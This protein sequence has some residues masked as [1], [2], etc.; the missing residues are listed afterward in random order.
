[1]ARRQLHAL[2]RHEI[3][4]GLML[5]RQM[6]VHRGDDF[7]IALRPGDLEHLRMPVENLL[8]LRS[9]APG[10]DDFAVLG[11]RFADRI[12]RLIHGGIDEA[13]GVHHHE[14]RRAV[15][16][17]HLVPFG[18]QAREDALRI[19]ERLGASQAD[20][21]HFG[22]LAIGQFS[23]E[24]KPWRDCCSRGA[25]PPGPTAAGRARGTP[26]LSAHSTP[27]CPLAGSRRTGIAPGCELHCQIR[28]SKTVMQ[29]YEPR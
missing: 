25:R 22:S 18:A 20:E 5:G 13:A 6:L 1:M 12:E 17:G 3:Q 15:A 23:I 29:C 19:D 8:R 21:A 28:L 9:Q 16:R 11:Q 4:K 14:I 27:K 24:S 2:R 10:D 26:K 7:F